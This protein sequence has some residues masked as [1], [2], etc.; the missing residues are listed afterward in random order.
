MAVIPA[1]VRVSKDA[2]ASNAVNRAAVVSSA[3]IHADQQRAR[4]IKEQAARAITKANINS[5]AALKGKD[6]PREARHSV[7][8]AGGK[9]NQVVI[10]SPSDVSSIQSSVANSIAA[11]RKHS[12]AS[13]DANAKP[14]LPQQKQQQQQQQKQQQQQQQQHIKRDVKHSRVPVSPAVHKRP[15]AAPA[16]IVGSAQPPAARRGSC[17]SNASSAASSAYTRQQK[18]KLIRERPSSGVIVAATPKESRVRSV[19]N[20][21]QPTAVAEPKNT[22][23]ASDIKGVRDGIA[24]T[25]DGPSK[26]S[27]NSISESHYAAAANKGRVSPIKRAAALRQAAAAY[28]AEKLSAVGIAIEDVDDDTNDNKAV[29]P[30]LAPAVTPTKNSQGLAYASNASPSDRWMHEL[31][32][33]PLL[34]PQRYSANAAAVSSIPSSSQYGAPQSNDSFD[35]KGSWLQDLEA[36]M[37]AVRAVVD[38]IQ[39]LKSPSSPHRA[40][41]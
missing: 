1:A 21:Y 20:V 36:K 17:A 7:V 35:S 4:Y 33:K 23:T 28:N 18:Q 26:R 12:A 29:S 16:K 15:A 6:A 14:T 27:A 32:I 10:S 19:A 2:L 8:S 34:S 39:L 22:G 40:S 30:P 3:M 31:G 5:D 37:G 24:L 41:S 25:S 11:R 38:D 9:Q 13:A